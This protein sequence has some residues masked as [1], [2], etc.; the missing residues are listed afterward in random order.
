MKT[1]SVYLKSTKTYIATHPWLFLLFIFTFWR[2][3][4]LFIGYHSTNQ[5][6]QLGNP[7]LHP[8]LQE[9]PKLLQPTF[10]FDSVH[11]LNIAAN[12]YGSTKSALP[13]FFPLFPALA[14]LGTKLGFHAVT[15][16][17]LVNFVAGYIAVVAL[18]G[19]ASIVF[20]TKNCKDI[21]F[22]VILFFL[23][24]PTAYFLTAFYTE[25]IFCALV[26]SAFYFALK[27]TWWASAVLLVFSTSLRFPALIFAAVIFIEYL[28][29]KQFKLKKIDS[30]ILWFLIVPAGLISYMLYLGYKFQDP[31]M[32]LHAYQYG[33]LYNHFSLNIFK[34]LAKHAMWIIQ[35]FLG[36]KPINPYGGLLMLL[37]F[38]GSWA[39]L[40]L[41]T[42][43]MIMKKYRISFI[44]LSLLML[45]MFLF[46]S[47]F[48]SVNRYLLPIFPIYLVFAD[49]FQNS[50]RIKQFTISISAVL[51]IFLYILFAN[52]FWTG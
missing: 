3:V 31:L 2:L 20:K 28:H 30:N 8:T 46:N 19:I 41:S 7:A 18:Y 38:F 1:F 32:F 4:L 33:W 6:G 49:I 48:V 44:I 47:N 13:A 45:L 52:G 11:Y 10:K 43:Y 25:A 5:L 23:F 17:F 34:T 36:Y 50:P 22:D 40:L 39:V 12:G 51:M 35:Y 9:V 15:F 27:R 26:F 14:R 16:G 21:K 29:S 37:M 24:F 42:I